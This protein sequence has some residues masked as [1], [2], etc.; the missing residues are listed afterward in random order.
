MNARVICMRPMPTLRA[1]VSNRILGLREAVDE[2]IGTRRKREAHAV[3][4][5]EARSLA[6]QPSSGNGRVDNFLQLMKFKT[7]GTWAGGGSP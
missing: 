3:L 6:P 5:R 2:G 7:P 4:L 1:S